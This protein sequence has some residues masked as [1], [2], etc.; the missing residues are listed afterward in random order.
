MDVDRFIIWFISESELY[1]NNAECVI[2]KTQT[3]E[4]TATMH[5]KRFGGG[6]RGIGRKKQQHYYAKA[7]R[8]Y[9][10]RRTQRGSGKKWDSFK[11]HGKQMMMKM[12]PYAIEA[13][14]KW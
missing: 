12:M 6:R 7:Q 10:R 2:Y 5:R 3:Q 8:G 9:G 4:I 14:S 11:K 1:I 13:V